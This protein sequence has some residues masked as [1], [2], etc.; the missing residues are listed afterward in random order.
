[1]YLAVLILWFYFEDRC[2]YMIGILASAR[3]LVRGF[4]TGWVPQLGKC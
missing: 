2:A 4:A 3:W 1:M